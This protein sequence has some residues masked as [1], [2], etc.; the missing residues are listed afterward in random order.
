MSANRPSQRPSRRPRD[1]HTEQH[2]ERSGPARLSVLFIEPSSL[3][4]AA[5]PVSANSLTLYLDFEFGYGQHRRRGWEFPRPFLANNQFDSYTSEPAVS[6]ARSLRRRHARARSGSKIR[7]AI[8]LATRLP[9]STPRPAVPARSSPGSPPRSTLPQP[10]PA[11]AH[12]TRSRRTK[13]RVS[14]SPPLPNTQG[15]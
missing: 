12:P 1:L 2:I 6:Q 8:P 3:R 5:G 15:R 9:D 14:T 4:R 10:R 13:A 11:S 7:I